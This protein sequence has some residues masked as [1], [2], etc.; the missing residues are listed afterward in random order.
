MP[1]AR[2]V[3]LSLVGLPDMASLIST[4]SVAMVAPVVT[5]VIVLRGCCA[6]VCLFAPLL[7]NQD[8]EAEVSGEAPTYAMVM[9]VLT[10]IYCTGGLYIF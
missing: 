7:F 1:P 6:V 8:V 2:P 5:K 10:W 3:S 9:E 4:Q